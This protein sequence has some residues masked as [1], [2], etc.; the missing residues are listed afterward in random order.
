MQ[1]VPSKRRYL[2]TNLHVVMSQGREIFV[3]KYIKK[4]QEKMPVNLLCR[5][6]NFNMADVTCFKEMLII[7]SEIL[8]KTKE[9]LNYCTI[10]QCQ[11]TLMC[12]FLTC[13]LLHRNADTHIGTNT[14]RL[15]RSVCALAIL[16][17]TCHYRI[18]SQSLVMHRVVWTHTAILKEGYIITASAGFDLWTWNKTY[19]EAKG[20]KEN[21]S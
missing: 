12:V 7:F 11:N 9:K 15:N 6:T 13:Q 8:K 16:C 14:R 10:R 20:C 4:E 19:H 18:N 5:H 21:H 17:D 1:Q 2:S 3:V